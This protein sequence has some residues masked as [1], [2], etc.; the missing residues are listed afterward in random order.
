MPFLK[1]EL[2]CTS[3]GMM[4]AENGL[5]TINYS[6]LP[7]PQSLKQHRF[8]S[9]CSCFETASEKQFDFNARGSNKATIYFLQ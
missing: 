4:Y 3:L 8:L 6:A 7:C 2:Y 9:N 1:R 5:G